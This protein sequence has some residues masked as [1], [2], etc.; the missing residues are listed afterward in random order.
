[1]PTPVARR[2]RHRGPDHRFLPALAGFIDHATLDSPGHVMV[3]V[4]GPVRPDV[5]LGLL[6]LDEGTHPFAELAGQHAPD[7][8]TVFG[9]RVTGMARR[10]DDPAAEPQR[11]SSVFLLD[12]RGGEASLLRQGD[13]VTEPSQP[14]VGTIPDLCRRVLRLPTAPPPPT[15]A[16]LW[17][18][19]WVDRIVD[20]WGQP[21]RRQDLTTFAQLAILHPAVHEPSPPDVLAVA[22][23]PSLARVA[24]PHAAATTWERLRFAADPL[25]LPDGPL[26]PWIAAWMD[27]G[28][29]ARWTIGAF[30][31]LAPTVLSLRHQLGPSLG[32]QLMEA[33]VLLLE[34]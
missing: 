16:L 17:A 8:W 13:D 12:R 28:F 21:H 3:R 15:T 33:M 2:R 31:P 32:R 27:D 24:R 7:D 34:R 25:P 20:R 6:P 9:L 22:D 1:M 5:N 14:A 26:D 10:L 23:P 4:E 29:F 30:P 11:T 18:A 19:T